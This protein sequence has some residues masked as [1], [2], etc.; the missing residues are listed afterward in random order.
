M[1]KRFVSESEERAAGN[2]MALHVERVL[3]YSMDG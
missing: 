3:D 2:E 1:L